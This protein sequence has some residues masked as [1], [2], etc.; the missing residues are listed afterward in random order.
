[1]GGG[2]GDE[3]HATG[4]D[5]AEAVLGESDGDDAGSGAEEGR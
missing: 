3:P 4:V 1:M 2:I 5:G